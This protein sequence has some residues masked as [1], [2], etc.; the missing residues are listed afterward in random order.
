MVQKPRKSNT[1]FLWGDGQDPI[2][3]C[4]VAVVNAWKKS[5][6]ARSLSCLI[7]GTSPV[8]IKQT[9]GHNSTLAIPQPGSNRQ[10]CSPDSQ[11]RHRNGLS[12][13]TFPGC[14]QKET[15]LPLQ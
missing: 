4:M 8:P 3:T 10:T 7:S 15:L 2:P 6:Q 14:N 12:K 1:V 11:R 13:G 9:T 5:A